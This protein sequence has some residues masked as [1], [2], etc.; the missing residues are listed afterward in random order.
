M[1]LCVKSPLGRRFCRFLV[2]VLIL[3]IMLHLIVASRSLTSI[4]RINDKVVRA[5]TTKDLQL[6]EYPLLDGLRGL[7]QFGDNCMMMQ[8]QIKNAHWY[9]A[10]MAP[11]PETIGDKTDTSVELLRYSREIRDNLQ[12]NLPTPVS[13]KF[14]HRYW[15]GQLVYCAFLLQVFDLA[16]V[17]MI[18][19]SATYLAFALLAVA[20]LWVSREAMCCFLPVVTFGICFS[21]VPYLGQSMIHSGYSI[22]LV[23][24]AL[25]FLV[26]DVKN[27]LNSIM[28]A[29]TIIGAV[30]VFVDQLNGVSL[31]GLC[32][33]MPTALYLARK[34]RARSIQP[35]GGL[36]VEVVYVATAFVC[37]VASAFLTIILHVGLQA[38]FYG[39][40]ATFGTTVFELNLRLNTDTT[41]GGAFK[42]LF[43]G[44]NVLTYGHIAQACALA[45][46]SLLAWMFGSFVFYKKLR[47]GSAAWTT[48]YPPVFVVNACASLLPF[49]WYALFRNHTQIHGGFMSRYLYL[50]MA[51]GWSNLL[52]LLYNRYGRAN[53]T[54]FD[55]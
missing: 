24:I 16:E 46:M 20:A 21:S 54:R 23:M 12:K 40:D 8:M 10:F 49:I 50:P 31:Q 37:M 9:D 29:S 13:K 19:K 43:I 36:P 38:V 32:L 3:N 42:S 51:L 34:Q 17:R 15:E 28:I 11:W 33:I 18:L 22:S 14:M 4:S 35:A 25:M 26:V 48:G 27:S 47:G 1:P 55:V 52:Y 30:S 41:L 7:D 53:E 39:F 44:M 5:Y 2:C 45:G 6:I